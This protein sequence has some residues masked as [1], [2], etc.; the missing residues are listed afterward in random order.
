MITYDSVL[1][2]RQSRDHTVVGRPIPQLC[3]VEIDD[4]YFD[5][6]VV[7]GFACIASAIVGKLVMTSLHE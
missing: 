7:F 5:R 4:R 3:P 1:S 2:G 6:L